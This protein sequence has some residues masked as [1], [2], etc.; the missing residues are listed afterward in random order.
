MIVRSALYGACLVALV[1]TGWWTTPAPRSVP[2]DQEKA[3]NEG[4]VIGVV[5]DSRDGHPVSYA[6]VV[7]IGTVCGSMT[8]DDGTFRI[9]GVPPG[10]Y[11]IKALAMGYRSVERGPIT[12]ETGKVTQCDFK[13]EKSSPGASRAERDFVG[14]EVEIE[15][16]DVVCEIHPRKSSFKVGERLEF[17]VRLQNL[18]DKTFYLIGCLDGS[19]S[20]PRYPFTY[21]SVFGPD[22]CTDSSFAMWLSVPGDTLDPDNF[23]QLRSGGSIDPFECGSGFRPDSTVESTRSHF[24]STY[25]LRKPG[26][27][28]IYFK[29]A[30]L[31]EHLGEWSGPSSLGAISNEVAGLL[32][33]VPRLELSCSAEFEVEQ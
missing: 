12:V 11:R 3:R 29:Y 1:F 25:A 8:L 26:H 7:V 13:I 17:D 33:K 14:S 32:R 20:P 18:S 19:V 15:P 9:S 28:T 31:E 10:T 6:N 16:K 21:W 27:Y 30:T 5:S 4:T 24:E 22:R 2:W 23:V